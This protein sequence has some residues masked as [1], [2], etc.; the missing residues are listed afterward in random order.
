MF[1]RRITALALALVCAVASPNLQPVQAKTKSDVNF[2]F[3]ADKP[4]KIILFRPDVEVGS[5][6]S[7]GVPTPNADW[8]AEARK[9][10]VASLRANQNAKSS[11]LIEMAELTGEDAGYIAEYQSLFK[12]V[13]QSMILHSYALKLPT[14]KMPNG[15]YKFDWTLGPGAQKLGAMGGGN[16]GLFVYNYDAY[17][18]AGRKA[19]QIFTLIASSALGFGVF[20]TGG[21]HVAYAALVDLDNGNIVWFNAYA[22]NKGDVRTV[23]GAKER[24]DT[25]LSTLPLREGEVAKKKTAVRR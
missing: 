8:T 4:I 10:I 2:R 25:L 9:N 7:S 20:P 14:K 3:P 15:K 17:A 12:A 19:M 1:M 5:L 23:E 18:T 16:Y 24:A 21:Q 11:E 6:G 22:K 13:G